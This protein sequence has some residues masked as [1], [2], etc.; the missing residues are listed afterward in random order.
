MRTVILCLIFSA[1]FM[2]TSAQSFQEKE[3]GQQIDSLVALQLKDVAPGG[4]VG[5]ISKGE[6]VYQ[7]SYGLMNLGQNLPVDEQ[8]LFDMASVAKQFTAFAI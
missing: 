3:I 4:V 5:V 2:A 1:L 8:T 6:I 7:Q